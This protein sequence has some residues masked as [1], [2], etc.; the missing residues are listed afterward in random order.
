M[1]KFETLVFDQDDACIIG[2]V[3]E[4]QE[5]YEA[6]GFRLVENDGNSRKIISQSRRR[7][8]C[9]N[10]GSGSSR[11][12]QHPSPD[13]CLATRTRRRKS[14]TKSMGSSHFGR[15]PTRISGC[16]IRAFSPTTPSMM[17]VLR[18]KI[19]CPG[20]GQMRSRYPYCHNCG[21]KLPVADGE[22]GRDRDMHDASLLM[23]KDGIHP[24]LKS[25]GMKYCPLCGKKL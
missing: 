13:G 15:G 10:Y 9:A 11:S 25:R 5:Q 1:K 17:E 7:H 23:G 24:K 18:E 22:R 8:R 14:H 4:L 2:G 19:K 6:Q 21:S 12:N 20:C 16:E 3:E